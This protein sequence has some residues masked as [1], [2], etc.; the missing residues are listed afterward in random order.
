MLC[1]T[2]SPRFLAARAG[3]CLLGLALLV[4]CDRL[5]L[6][7]ARE[8]SVD[9]TPAPAQAKD[10]KTEP[11]PPSVAIPPGGPTKTVAQSPATP[12]VSAGVSTATAEPSD[13]RN[14][15]ARAPNDAGAEPELPLTTDD[16][17]KPL[18]PPPEAKGLIRMPDPEEKGAFQDLWVDK[19]KK[20]IVLAGRICKRTGEME[21]FA[22]F[23]RTKEHESIV[24]VRARGVAI[25]ATLMALGIR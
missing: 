13:D 24:S 3:A 16:L 8:A 4:G 20:Q 25:H 1:L 22:C 7:P 11:A 12:R 15:P 5:G 10:A 14:P 9:K 18:E 17:D 23:R 2:S 21:L 6:G 19:E